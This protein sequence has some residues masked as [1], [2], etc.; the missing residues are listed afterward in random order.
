M[1]ET[2][3]DAAQKRAALK[4][5]LESEEFASAQRLKAF[6]SYIVEPEIAGNENKIIGKTILADVY[7]NDARSDV[8]T[9]TVVHVDAN[10]MRQRLESY[11]NT[12]RKND[13]V[14]LSV[15][16]GGYVSRYA[17]APNANIDEEPQNR[18]IALRTRTTAI[19][20]SL[21]AV[22]IAAFAQ[23]LACFLKNRVTQTHSKCHP[24]HEPL[25]LRAPP[26]NSR[27]ATPRKKHESCCSQ[28]RGFFV[29]PL[30]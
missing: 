9:A 22:A 17:F 19:V 10:R 4:R 30:R 1:T 11:Y 8:D 2:E 25:F 16:K 3:I 29:F 27:P 14:H 24:R 12:E 20:G 13:P 26:E 28:P 21:A 23:P 5:L 18:G 7:N 15:D 6:M